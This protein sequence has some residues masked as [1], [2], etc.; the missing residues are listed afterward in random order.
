MIT[1]SYIEEGSGPIPNVRLSDEEYVRGLQCFIPLCTD[2][3]P[4]NREKK[5]IYLAKRAAKPM[6]GWWWLGGKMNPSETKES[7]ALRCLKRETGLAIS[8]DR[9]QLVAFI[10]IHWKD[11]QQEP[12]TIGCHM[13]D[14]I[15]AVEFS[16]DELEHIRTNLEGREYHAGEGLIPFDRNGLV[17]AGVFPTILDVYDTLFPGV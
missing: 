7:S 3:V 13:A 6:Q 14:Y 10:D 17:E 8:D 11:R 16:D 4:V 9:L 15:F 5:L 12:Q 1:K 2:I